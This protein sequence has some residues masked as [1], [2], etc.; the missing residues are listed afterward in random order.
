MDCIF[1]GS[2]RRFVFI[3]EKFWGNGMMGF[4]FRKWVSFE[5]ETTMVENLR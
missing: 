1:C 5:K 3:D 2:F 4:S